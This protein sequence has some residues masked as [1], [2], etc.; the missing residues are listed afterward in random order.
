MDLFLDETKQE[1]KSLLLQRKLLHQKKT[2]KRSKILWF[3]F[4]T[5][6][7]VFCSYISTRQVLDYY[8]YKTD[9]VISLENEQELEFPTITICNS[10]LCGFNNYNCT[11]YF[12]DYINRLSNQEEKNKVKDGLSKK[13]TKQNLDLAN[14]CF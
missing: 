13:N 2:T 1:V 6:S 10:Q 8:D 7:T 4:I 9:T 12:E 3:L 11:K 5:V 14:K